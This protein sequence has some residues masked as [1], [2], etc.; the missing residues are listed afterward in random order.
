LH[1]R[2][3]PL[4]LGA[5]VA[6]GGTKEGAQKQACSDGKGEFGESRGY[7]KWRRDVDGQFVVVA[8]AEVLDDGQF[9][10]VAAAQVLDERMPLDDDPPRKVRLSPDPPTG[11]S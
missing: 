3:L 2:T 7:A 9:V 10:V 5:A 11:D 1:P 8:A 4:L 6:S